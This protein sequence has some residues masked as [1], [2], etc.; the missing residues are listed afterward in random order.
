MSDFNLSTISISLIIVCFL[1][2][3]YVAII[4]LRHLRVVA[5][6]FHRLPHDIQ[7]NASTP[8][9][10]SVVVYTHNDAST[11]ADYID[12]VMSQKGVEYEVIVVDDA[13]S[14]YT[15][16]ILDGLKDKYLA[17]RTTFVPNDSHSLS[18][19]KLAL[20]LGIKAA[21][22]D[23]II[24]TTANCKILSNR[25][26]YSIVRHFENPKTDITLGYSHVDKTSQ[27]DIFRWYRSFDSLSTSSLWLGYAL[28]KAPYRGD[29]HNLA[30]RRK[31]FFEQNGYARTIYLHHGDDDLFINQFATSDNTHVEICRESQLIVDWGVS[32]PRL[33]LDN[34]ERY[35]FTARYLKTKAFIDRN[36]SQSAQWLMTLTGITTAIYALPNLVPGLLI[37]LMFIMLWGYQIYLYRR[38]SKALGAIRLWWSIPLFMLMQPIIDIIYRAIFRTR[39]SANYTWRRNK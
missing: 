15:A 10:A 1:S 25:W 16:N 31:C 12:S 24:S 30:F 19:R 17:L 21:K 36:I 22:H 13:S 18:H 28:S 26:L 2:G 29:G 34:K 38:A 20:T 32:E 27:K 14:D 37:T 35:T 23:V 9:K 39:K 33:W 11:I 3:L 4:G 6:H 8:V 5:R 7:D